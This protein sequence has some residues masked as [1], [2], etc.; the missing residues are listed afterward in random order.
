M[1]KIILGTILGIL[2]GILILGMINVVSAEENYV[3]GEL[4]IMFQKN[5]ANN[6]INSLLNKYHL[7]WGESYPQV[8]SSNNVWG[9]VLVPSGSENKFIKIL[10]KEPIILSAELNIIMYPNSDDASETDCSKVGNKTSKWNNKWNNNWKRFSLSN[11]IKIKLKSISKK[12][13]EKTMKGKSFNSLYELIEKK[14]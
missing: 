12:N 10:K 1:G 13:L 11:N 8:M 5:V 14:K 7:A 6:S 2:T 4:I 9:V 3:C